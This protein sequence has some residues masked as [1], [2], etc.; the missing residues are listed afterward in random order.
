MQSPPKITTYTVPGYSVTVDQS[1]PTLHM[2]NSAPTPAPSP[3]SPITP[4]AVGGNGMVWCNGP[5]AGPQAPGYNVTTHKCTPI[6]TSTNAITPQQTVICTKTNDPA[7]VKVFEQHV[8]PQ[9]QPTVVQLSQLPY[10]GD[11]ATDTYASAMLYIGAIAFSALAIY[12][13]LQ[14]KQWL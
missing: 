3:Q 11:N 12:R 6:S 7:C 5:Q 2:N 1:E 8:T 10:T 13:I 14:H 4:V 9:I